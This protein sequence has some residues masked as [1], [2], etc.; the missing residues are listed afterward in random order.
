MAADYR[1]GNPTLETEISD[2][3][4]GFSKSW[5]VPYTVTDGPASGTHGHVMVPAENY[6]A[7]NVHAAIQT[8]VKTHHEVMGR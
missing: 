8:A 1:V 6:S 2:T 7:D 4:T 3:G 5:K